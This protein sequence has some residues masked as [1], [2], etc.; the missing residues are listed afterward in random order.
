MTDNS[1]PQRASRSKSREV[2]MVAPSPWSSPIGSSNRSSTKP[3]SKTP[4]KTPSKA[5]RTPKARTPKGTPLKKA[6]VLEEDDDDEEEQ[7]ND[8]VM[9][10]AGFRVAD[11]TDGLENDWEGE[12]TQE[13]GDEA[14]TKDSARSVTPK[15]LNSSPSSK[16]SKSK[17]NE[18]TS[19]PTSAVK[20]SRRKKSEPVKAAGKKVV[21][22]DDEDENDG[23]EPQVIEQQYAMEDEVVAGEN[24]KEDDDDEDDDDDDDEA[25]E[26]VS[27]QHAKKAAEVESLRK[28]E[29]AKR[30]KEEQRQLTAL[31]QQQGRE[32]KLAKAEKA[33]PVKGIPLGLLEAAEKMDKEREAFERQAILERRKLQAEEAKKRRK[34]LDEDDEEGEAKKKKKSKKDPSG[35]VEIQGFKI[36]PLT[37]TANRP[38][39]LNASNTVSKFQQKHFFGERVQR[40]P[41]PPPCSIS[42]TSSQSST[43]SQTLTEIQGGVVAPTTTSTQSSTASQ[44]LTEIQGGVVTPATTSGASSTAVP[45]LTDSQGGVLSASTPTSDLSSSP[46]PTLT[47]IQGGVINASTTTSSSRTTSSAASQTFT[48]IQGGVVN[49]PST[50]SVISAPTSSSP[51]TSS[52]SASAGSSSLPNTSSLALSS[53]PTSSSTSSASSASCPTPFSHPHSSAICTGKPKM[54]K[55]GSFES[56]IF[57]KGASQIVAFDSRRT[58]VL[59]TNAQNKTVDIIDISTPSQPVKIKSVYPNFN[60]THA[61]NSVAVFGDL[62][63]VAIEGTLKTDPGWVLAPCEGEPNDDYSVDPEGGIAIIDL[64]EGP[65]KAVFKVADFK[66]F[67]S[68]NAPANVRIGSKAASVAQDLEP[69]YIAISSDS[70]KAFA[71]LQENNAIAV[72]DIGSATVEKMLPLGVKNFSTTALDVSDKDGKIDIR[73]WNRVVGLYQPDNIAYYEDKDTCGVT[74]GEY[75]F[76]ANEG[77]GRTYGNYTDEPR[78]KDLTLNADLF[79]KTDISGLARLTVSSEDGYT[80]VNGTKK[81]FHT[82][83][84]FGARSFSIWK[85]D[86]GEQV[87]DSGDELEKISAN[88][89]PKY[90][91]SNNNEASSFDTRS[92]NRGPEPE[93]LITG[94]IGKYPLVFIGNERQSGIMMYD[95]TDIRNPVLLQYFNQRKWDVEIKSQGDLGP[96]GFDFVYGEN[97]PTG[98]PL[99][100]VGNEVSGSTAIYE[101]TC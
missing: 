96:E 68:P 41:A 72:I 35:A 20:S 71:S 8:E 46:L 87:F 62:A 94:R 63:A 27:I 57:D 13:D 32:A 73:T 5:P 10:D 66:Q 75:I 54:T 14:T 38:I 89:E 56:M 51:T 18:S 30:L 67:N 40:A 3:A 12:P 42:R 84:T 101:I 17:S 91:N 39:Q 59:I 65:L 50:T 25:P 79:S 81:V 86:T 48:E 100:I 82:L 74:L 97:S 64:T 26:A 43:A 15:K 36:I 29:E 69:E 47:E 34:R 49:A 83:H 53:T 9:G 95:I 77:D 1:T 7:E 21:F 28:L 92:D 85:A 11:D 90:F 78:A 55:L 61:L 45:T 76:T 44:T 2:Q 98:N 23:M 88:V 37:K 33:Q 99:L 80:I 93:A 52:S 60:S 6:L 16:D 22:D 58:R 24:S 19:N 70:K 31:R 4:T